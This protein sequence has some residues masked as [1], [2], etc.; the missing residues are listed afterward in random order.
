MKTITTALYISFCLSFA[1]CGLSK[2]TSSLFA[3]EVCSCLF[4]S[5]Q[6]KKYCV[7]YGQ[8]ALAVNR[9]VIDSE[10]KTVVAKK[11]ISKSKARY[12]SQRLGC[13]L[14]E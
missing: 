1:S 11:L 7:D 9:Y 14:L 6:S 3:K 12:V 10:N 5:D 4:V 8:P 13:E 2:T